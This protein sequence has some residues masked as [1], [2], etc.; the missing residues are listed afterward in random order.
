MGVALFWVLPEIADYLSWF[1]AFLWLAAGFGALWL[2]DRFVH[3]VC[4]ACSHPHD[5]D[6]CSAELHGF[7]PPLLIAAAVH[8][9]LDGWTVSAADGPAHLGMPF[10]MA[11][12]VHKIPEGLALGV[13][14]RAAMASRRAALGWCLLAE[15]ATL[16]GAGLELV[17]APLLEPQVLYALLAIAGGTFLYLGGHAIHGEFRRKG[18]APGFLPA[19]AGIASPSVFRLFRLL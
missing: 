4:P 10:M 16:G 1:H 9:A 14:V 12:A 7:A 8:S 6:H 19:L 5:H 13:I 18:V 15:S 11:I 17:V 2:V 3:P